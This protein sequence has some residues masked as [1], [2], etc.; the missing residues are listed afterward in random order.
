MRPVALANAPESSATTGEDKSSCQNPEEREYNKGG[1]RE[2]LRTKLDL[3]GL[4]GVELLTPSVHAYQERIQRDE[5]SEKKACGSQKM[6][7][8]ERM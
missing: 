4:V 3:G 1:M 6:S 5:R 2:R 8:T 7:L